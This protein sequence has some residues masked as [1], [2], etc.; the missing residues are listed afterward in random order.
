LEKIGKFHV[1]RVN[2]T[3]MPFHLLDKFGK[4]NPD[5]EQNPEKSLIMFPELVSWLVFLN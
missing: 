2:S 3:K 4:E 5:H 1:F